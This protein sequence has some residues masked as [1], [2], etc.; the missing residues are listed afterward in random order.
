LEDLN[1]ELREEA[2]FENMG[3]VIYQFWGQCSF[4]Y[5]PFSVCLKK[6]WMETIIIEDEIK[7]HTNGFY[8]SPG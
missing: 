6:Q 8:N 1:K 7:G 3:T 5:S 4:S 2:S